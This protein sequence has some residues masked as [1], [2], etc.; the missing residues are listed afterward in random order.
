MQQNEQTTTCV[1]V[2]AGQ[3]GATS[4]VAA[5][6]A[7]LREAQGEWTTFP[8]GELEGRRPKALC[9]ACL[10]QLGRATV[11]QLGTPRARPVCFQCYR[12]EFER[13]R[14]LQ[15]AGQLDTA[16]E[17]RFRF[18]L[19]FE[20]VNRLRLEM[21]RAERASA[22]AMTNAGPGRFTNRRRQAQMAARRALR[23]IAAGLEAR[24]AARPVRERAMVAAAHGAEL[25]PLEAW[26][27]FVVSS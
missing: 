23:T 17:E 3:Y 19:P 24:Q 6:R 21:L 14:T 26:V 13:E 1:E 25:Q 15:A 2:R 11:E 9:P 20:S 22:R 27:P 18:A 4:L 8:G 7:D 10:E 12:A 5:W 16:S